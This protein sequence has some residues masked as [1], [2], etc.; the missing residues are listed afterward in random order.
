[1]R[2]FGNLPLT[3]IGRRPC[4]LNMVDPSSS[5]DECKTCLLPAKKSSL[6]KQHA[7]LRGNGTDIPN[8]IGVGAEAVSKHKE[9][10]AV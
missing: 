7:K 9:V 5:A 3:H 4:P 2:L 1:M 6:E 8:P 10:E